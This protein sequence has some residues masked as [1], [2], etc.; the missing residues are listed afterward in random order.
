MIFSKAIIYK[1]LTKADIERQNII[2]WVYKIWTN[3]KLITKEK[4]KKFYDDT[5]EKHIKGTNQISLVLIQVADQ[6]AA[7]KINGSSRSYLSLHRS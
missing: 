3:E 1:N 2:R 5:W 7:E 6:K 4:L